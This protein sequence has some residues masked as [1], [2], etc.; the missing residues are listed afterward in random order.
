[1]GVINK[2]IKSVYTRTL[3]RNER[4]IV[5]NVEM[6]ITFYSNETKKKGEKKTFSNYLTLQV[7]QFLQ[8][9]CNFYTDSIFDETIVAC[10]YVFVSSN[11]DIFFLD[12]YTVTFAFIAERGGC[13]GS[14]GI[15]EQR[16]GI[17]PNREVSVSISPCG[18]ISRWKRACIN[19][20]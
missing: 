11:E 10:A 4:R 15:V 13:R 7:L 8:F 17:V 6:K 18:Y 16:R 2:V 3:A 20:W 5:R 19:E 14:W 9:N 12:K 1:M